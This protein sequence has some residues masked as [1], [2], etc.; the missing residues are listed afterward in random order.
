M[1][2]DQ[3][4]VIGYD[5]NGHPKIRYCMDPREVTIVRDPERDGEV[6]GYIWEP[7]GPVPSPIRTN[8]PQLT[9]AEVEDF[10]RRF[11]AAQRKPPTWHRPGDEAINVHSIDMQERRGPRGSRWEVATYLGVGIAAIALVWLTLAL[12]YGTSSALTPPAVL[13]L[14][15]AL[16]TSVG[17]CGPLMEA[18][19]LRLARE[20]DDAGAGEFE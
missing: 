2:D 1:T 7:V 8:P 11:L 16:V 18:R 20:T 5:E 12:V 14:V 9:D 6:I 4:A 3:F 17:V 13:A 19:K 15:G 10:K